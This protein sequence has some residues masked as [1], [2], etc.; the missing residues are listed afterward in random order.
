[1]QLSKECC[2]I[3]LKY[4]QFWANF[5]FDKPKEI[6]DQALNYKHFQIFNSFNGLASSPPILIIARTIKIF[7]ILFLYPLS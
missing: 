3:I 1:M 5:L 2:Y 4:I 6:E 7:G